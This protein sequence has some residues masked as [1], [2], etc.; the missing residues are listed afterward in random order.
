MQP[1]LMYGF[2][3][4]NVIPFELEHDVP[5]FGYKIHFPRGKV[6]YATDMANLNGIV[7]KGYDLYM[8]EANYQKDEIKAR[9]DAKKAEGLYTYEQRVLKYHMSKEDCDNWLVKNGAREYMYLHCHEERGE[10]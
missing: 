10:S 1:K 7:A 2:G 8:V 3:I 4:C 9:M 6:F 5:C